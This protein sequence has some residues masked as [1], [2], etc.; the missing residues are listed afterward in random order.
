MALIFFSIWKNKI[1]M[2]YLLWS[3][4]KD[5]ISWS[6][7][8]M[9]SLKLMIVQDANNILLNHSIEIR[10]MLKIN[11][12]LCWESTDFNYDTTSSG[13]SDI[14]NTEK[15]IKFKKIKKNLPQKLLRLKW[16]IWVSK[17]WNFKLNAEFLINWLSYYCPAYFILSSL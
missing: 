14:V 5:K 15:R 16:P 3:V 4:L 6:R 1:F 13:W 17:S 9:N 8:N 2:F 11:K 7:S 10:K 12:I